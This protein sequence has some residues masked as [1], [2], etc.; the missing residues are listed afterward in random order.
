MRPFEP[1]DYP[2]ATHARWVGLLEQRLDRHRADNDALRNDERQTAITRG[3]IAEIKELLAMAT[4]PSPANEADPDEASVPRPH[5][6]D[7]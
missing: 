1:Q 2:S 3:R 6:E 4:K 5:Y 7:T